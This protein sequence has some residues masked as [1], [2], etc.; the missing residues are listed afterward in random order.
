MT[1][2]KKAELQRKLSMAPVPKPPA[3]LLDRLKADIP[4]QLMSTERE[5]DRLSRSLS[6]SMRVA[7]S[8]I[9]LV[10]SVFLSL[11]IF[12][13]Q[14]GVSEPQFASEARRNEAPA[15]TAAPP[16]AQPMAEVTVTMADA[17]A[18][19][20]KEIAADALQS[21]APRRADVPTVSQAKPFVG[22]EEAKKDERF[23]GGKIGGVL[24]NAV[25]AA[26]PEPAAVPA[27]PA[28]PPPPAVVENIAV[29]AEAAPEVRRQSA[30]AMKS[31]RQVA[32]LASAAPRTLFGISLDAKEFAR[33]REMIDS[34]EKPPAAGV[35]IDALVNHFAGSA[36]P[37]RPGVQLQIEGSR[38][39]LTGE[40]EIAIL[41]YTIDTTG[42]GP[43]VG[44]NAVLDIDMNEGVIRTYRIVSQGAALRTTEPVL[45]NGISATGLIEVALKPNLSPRTRVATVRLSYRA[46]KTGRQVLLSD[47]VQVSEL[48]RSWLEASHR[49]RLATLGAVWGASLKGTPPADEVARTAE[50]LAKREPGDARARDLAAAAS[51]ASRLQSSGPT[52]SGR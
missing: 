23:E 22:V 7:A 48:R 50:E 49:H 20:E 17:V 2:K 14:K 12:E 3:G 9:L 25:A 4:E 33:L 10:T 40:S 15:K 8:I 47:V 37:Q 45:S 27:A 46:A 19:K 43:S 13:R 41:R 16:P 11:Q 44:T 21:A 18:P 6:F 36:Q 5:R 26:E 24:G 35:N 42:E 51:A 31:V 30:L 34:G 29:T 28:P 38:A 1:Q 32:D 39:P 52:G